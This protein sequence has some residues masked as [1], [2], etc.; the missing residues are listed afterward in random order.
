MAQTSAPKL[1]GGDPFPQMTIAMVDGSSLKIPADLRAD[2]T[3]FLGYRGK[4]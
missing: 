1:D 3:I 2:Y 4:W